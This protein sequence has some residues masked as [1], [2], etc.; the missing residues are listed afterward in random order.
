MQTTL[1]VQLLPQNY[2]RLDG[3]GLQQGRRRHPA[4]EDHVIGRLMRLHHWVWRPTSV[5]IPCTQAMQISVAARMP[6]LR[7]AG[8]EPLTAI[9]HRLL[10]AAQPRMSPSASASR[11]RWQNL[12][13][14]PN[15][16]RSLSTCHQ[17][18]SFSVS[19]KLNLASCLSIQTELTRYK[20]RR[21][22]SVAG[23]LNAKAGTKGT[24]AKSL[25]PEVSRG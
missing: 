7:K 22:L 15:R 19:S 3:K 21:A 10:V 4:R 16:L 9:R 23:K 18:S 14:P 11:D 5:P 2:L 24:S 20:T 12:F 8:H 25:T 6:E 13:A 17:S 1:D